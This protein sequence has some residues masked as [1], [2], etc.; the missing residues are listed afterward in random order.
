MSGP[1]KGDERGII[2]RSVE[3]LLRNAR[4]M[5]SQGWEVDITVSIVEIYN[6]DIRDLL[7]K[8]SST[9]NNAFT[10][11]TNAK[12]KFKIGRQNGRVV[13][14]GLTNVSIYI[15][16]D[17]PGHAEDDLAMQQFYDVFNQSMEARSTASTGMNEVSSR[18]HLIVMIDVM[19]TCASSTNSSTTMTLHGGLRLCDLAGSERLDRTNTL[20]DATR[21]RETV[22]INKSLSCLADVFLALNNKAPHVPYR[23]SKLTMLLQDCLSGDGKAL[24]FVNVSPTIASSA[25]TLCS[26]RFASQVSQVELGKAQKHVMTTTVITQPAPAPAPVPVQQVAHSAGPV[27][28][29]NRRGSLLMPPPAPTPLAQQ[30]HQQQLHVAPMPAASQS[31]QQNQQQQLQEALDTSMDSVEACHPPPATAMKAPTTAPSTLTTASKEKSVRFG[32]TEDAPIA[33]VRPFSTPAS[34]DQHHSSVVAR[35]EVPKPIAQP[36]SFLSSNPAE[37]PLA[38][39][40]SSVLGSA[41]APA[42]RPFRQL[43]ASAR[44]TSTLG[45]VGGSNL[46][47]GAKT[48][49]VSNTVKENDHV[50]SNIVTSSSSFLTNITST[51]NKRDSSHLLTATS[52]DTFLASGGVANGNGSAFMNMPA[53]RLRGGP[54]TDSWLLSGAATGSMGT[55]ATAMP[56]SSTNGF[57]SVGPFSSLSQPAQ[58]KPSTWR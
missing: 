30:Q 48:T 40:T 34:D 15:G 27:T 28:R 38:T 52:S 19:A 23:N 55:V 36:T 3:E 7:A 22:N 4:H 57:S 9:Q 8:P 11:N 41:V 53:K 6:E 20:H 42:S 12:E 39:S 37:R 50:V 45:A 47:S 46:L 35:R 14:A 43:G 32:A 16:H 24:M 18:S 21:L 17:N 10:A 56:S 29:S 51:T 54:S 2:P 31:N 13:V 33:S 49:F 5:Q 25:E 26:L 1:R 58:R 44:R